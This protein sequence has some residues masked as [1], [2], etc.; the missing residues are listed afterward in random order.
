MKT[1]PECDSGVDDNFQLRWDRRII[2][3]VLLS[4]AAT[5]FLAGQTLVGI[6]GGLNYS[7][8]PDKVYSSDVVSETYGGCPIVFYWG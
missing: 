7:K 3:T 6:S 8:P 1:Y 4:L 2:L 5:S